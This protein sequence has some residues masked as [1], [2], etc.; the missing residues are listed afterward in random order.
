MIGVMSGT[1]L[2]GVDLAHCTFSIEEGYWHYKINAAYT[3]P[4]TPFW[5][6]QLAKLNELNGYQFQRLDVEYG[7]ML[8]ELVNT[9][10]ENFKLEADLIVSH[11]HTAF[12]DPSKRISKQIGDPIGIWSITEIPVVAE[13]RQADVLKNGQGAPLVPVA[14]W[15]LFNE[16]PICL[17]LGGI[18]NISLKSN[19]LNTITAFDIAPCNLII[20][21]LAAQKGF[22]YDDKGAMAKQG[23]VDHSTLETLNALPFYQKTGPKSLD[24]KAVE[25]KYFPILD[26]TDLTV[27]DKLATYTEHL[28]YQVGV[29]AKASSA[30][31]DSIIFIT[32]GGAFNDFLMEK[33]QRYSGLKIR[34]PANTLIEYKEALAFAFMGLLRCKNEINCFKSVTGA[35]ESHVAGNLYGDFTAIANKLLREA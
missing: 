22:P 17:N 11:G 5:E 30:S 20:N 21:H 16:Y 31:E 33:I 34:K 2:D 1:S 10:K 8:G 29:A 4:Y 19:K 26:N 32:G 23:Y 14:D 35:W 9:F 3:I 18:A 6:E 13:F 7:T 28:A 27:E 12:H 25:E 15:W 24:K